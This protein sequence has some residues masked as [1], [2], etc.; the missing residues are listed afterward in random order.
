M[1]L[2][3]AAATFL[4]HIGV[5]GRDANELSQVTPVYE[6]SARA[7]SG[8]TTT[9]TT[10]KFIDEVGDAEVRTLLSDKRKFEQRVRLES[11]QYNR[12]ELRQVC[13]FHGSAKG[14]SL[15]GLCHRRHDNPMSVPACVYRTTIGCSKGNQCNYRHQVFSA[16]GERLSA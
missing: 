7:L 1:A 15:G 2:D 11:T 13:K 16:E 14:C 8:P 3:G 12:T 5:D 6:S 9:P 4:S 10:T